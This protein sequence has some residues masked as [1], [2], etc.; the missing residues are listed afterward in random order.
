MI[1]TLNKCTL[2]KKKKEVAAAEVGPQT[3][4]QE[5]GYIVEKKSI[6]LLFCLYNFWYRLNIF[7]Y[8]LQIDMQI[9]ML[10]VLP[11][12]DADDLSPSRPVL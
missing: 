3:G 7:E 5:Q 4:K 9:Q 12:D 1:Q 10:T 2:K 11:T 8:F 6:D